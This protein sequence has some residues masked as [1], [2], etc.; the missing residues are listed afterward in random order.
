MNDTEHLIEEQLFQAD[1]MEDVRLYQLEEQVKRQ[2]TR[3]EQMRIELTHMARL[4]LLWKRCAHG[5]TRT[6]PKT[7]RRVG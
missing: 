1:A 3:I 7:Q 2:K 6:W 5:M 4:V